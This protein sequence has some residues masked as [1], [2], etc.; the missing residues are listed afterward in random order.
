MKWKPNS[1]VKRQILTRN[2]HFCDKCINLTEYSNGQ[3]YVS[4]HDDEDPDNAYMCAKCMFNQMIGFEPGNTKELR[5]ELKPLDPKY[6]RWHHDTYHVIQYENPAR[7]F[8][9]KKPPELGKDNIFRDYDN[10]KIIELYQIWQDSLDHK[11]HHVRDSAQRHVLAL[12]E[13]IT[14]REITVQQQLEIEEL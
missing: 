3:V 10:A 9:T 2:F 7:G 8:Y 6:D 14:E 4:T 5:C 13:L 11:W 1:T 12:E